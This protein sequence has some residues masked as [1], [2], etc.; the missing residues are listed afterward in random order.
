M[1]KEYL[2]LQEKQINLLNEYPYST[3]I[4]YV[5]DKESN[6]IIDIMKVSEID[7]EYTSMDEIV[8]LLNKHRNTIQGLKVTRG[9]MRKSIKEYSK[10][11]SRLKLH[12]HMKYDELKREFDW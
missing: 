7:N 6:S 9:R 12:I 2:D 3:I 10:E 5:Y 1:K 4:Y 11:L 8:D